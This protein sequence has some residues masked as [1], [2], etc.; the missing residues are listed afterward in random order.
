MQCP[1]GG[2]ALARGAD[3]GAYVCEYCGTSFAAADILG[4]KRVDLGPFYQAALAAL[5]GGDYAGAYEYFNRILE[6]DP[7]QSDAWVGKAAAGLFAGWYRSQDVNAAEA[8]TCFETALACYD[9]PNRGRFEQALADRAGAA[10]TAVFALV[11]DAGAADKEN[12]EALL[13]LLKY[14]EKKGTKEEACW[15]AILAVAEEAVVP[16]QREAG[17]TYLSFKYPYKAL[18]VEYAGKIRARY[19]PNLVTEYERRA[20][21]WAEIKRD[22][23]RVGKIILVVLI[24]GTAAAILIIALLILL[25]AWAYFR[26]GG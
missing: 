6:L 13:A 21:N 23:G 18:A 1:K 19:D 25:G 17:T 3:A 26:T 5:D 4:G 24:A 10:A 7:K 16:S 20:E 11:K 14:W 12:V 22:V 15:R 2:G 8:L 9:G